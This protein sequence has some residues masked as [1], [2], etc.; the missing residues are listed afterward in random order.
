MRKW[1]MQLTSSPAEDVASFRLGIVGDL[2]RA[3]SRRNRSDTLKPRES[4]RSRRGDSQ[5]RIERA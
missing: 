3:M 2:L 5:H 4:L 1:T